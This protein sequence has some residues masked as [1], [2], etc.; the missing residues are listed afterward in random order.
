MCR[1]RNEILILLNVRGGSV[2]D[3]WLDE[4]WIRLSVLRGVAAGLD[5]GSGRRG[6]EDR[7]GAGSG[8]GGV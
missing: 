8:F 2:V 3:F 1:S 5:L 6:E 4:F 7:G